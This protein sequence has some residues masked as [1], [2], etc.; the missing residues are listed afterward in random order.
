MARDADNLIHRSL[1]NFC[2]NKLP[3]LRF[4]PNSAFFIACPCGLFSL[5]SVQRGCTTPVVPEQPCAVTLRRNLV[6]VAAKIVAHAG[7]AILKL[8]EGAWRP[9]FSKK[10]WKQLSQRSEMAL[11]L[12]AELISSENCR[13]T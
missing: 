10:L 7:R 3:F 1:K 4:A 2:F 13:K 6:D 8:K 5:R 11:V 12:I 9:F